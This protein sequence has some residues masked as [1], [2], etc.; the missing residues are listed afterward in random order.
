MNLPLNYVAILLAALSSLIVG[1]VWYLPAVFG[2]RFQALT[3][4]DPNKPKRP[5]VTYA[6]TFV[7]S[8]FTA[9]VLAYVTFL[10]YEYFHSDILTRALL[11]A[12]FLWLGFTAARLL[13]H[14]L[15]EQ[16]TLRVYLITIGHELVTVLVM[17][18]IIA[19][20]R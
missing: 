3:G 19:L 6:L 8:F 12:F 15:F 1:T 20:L 11:T 5:I 7:G 14:D 2:R 4:V 18:V 10:T 13:I 17:A 9:Y 16:R